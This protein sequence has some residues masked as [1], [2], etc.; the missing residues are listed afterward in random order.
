MN[1]KNRI[2][3]FLL[4]LLCIGGFYF[5]FGIYNQGEVNMNKVSTEL[6]INST[7]LIASFI[8]NEKSANAIYRDKVLE[9]DGMIKEINFFNNRNTVILYGNNPSTSV[10][11]DMH[12]NQMGA[13]KKFKQGQEIIIK[14]VCKGFLKDVVLLNCVLI[15]KKNP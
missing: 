12:K 8:H 13:I 4:S 10:L 9:V 3:Y 1:R 15:N 11:C 6:E 2:V 14:G 5:Y 7:D